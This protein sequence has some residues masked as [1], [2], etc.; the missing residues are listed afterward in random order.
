VYDTATGREILCERIPDAW[1][2]H[3]QFSPRDNTQILYNHEWCA[4]SGIRRMWLWD[5]KRHLR[6]RTEGEGVSRKDW[7]CHEMW[8][9]DGAWIIYHGSYAA[10]P[11]YIGRVR[12][13]GSGRTEIALPAEWTR[14]GHF[15]VG[16]PGELVSDGYYAQPGDSNPGWGGS[17][18]C[19][20]KADWAAKKLE[21]LPLCRSGSSWCSQDCHPHP[22]CN[23]AADTTYFTSD[24]SG[25]RAVYRITAEADR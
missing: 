13:D 16:K 24:K 7:T 4:D 18:I 12:P 19:R 6:L 11:A 14:Y 8:E 5:G 17:W 20:I 15:T 21:W 2:T 10:G 23:H 25:R 3:V 1:V 9:R 22:V